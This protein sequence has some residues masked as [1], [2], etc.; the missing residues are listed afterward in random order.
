MKPVTLQRFPSESGLR[1]LDVEV[2]EKVASGPKDR[3]G[4]GAVD[5]DQD[6][7]KLKVIPSIKTQVSF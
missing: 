3:S 2:F 5:C 4:N 6:C 7:E 1:R